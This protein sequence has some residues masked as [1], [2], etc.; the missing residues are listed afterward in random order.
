MATV[1]PKQMAGFRV[2][3]SSLVLGGH[4]AAEPAGRDESSAAFAGSCEGF[5][6]AISPAGGYCD[7]DCIDSGDCCPDSELICEPISANEEG[8]WIG[9]PCTPGETPLAPHRL[10]WCCGLVGKRVRAARERCHHR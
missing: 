10:H 2:L 5:C 3:A 6:G 1:G 8:R 7:A 9:T 4:D